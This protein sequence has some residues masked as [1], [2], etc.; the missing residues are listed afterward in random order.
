MDYDEHKEKIKE[1]AEGEFH[2]DRG[3]F[4]P[5]I[6]YRQLCLCFGAIGVFMVVFMALYAELDEIGKHISEEYRKYVTLAF[7]IFANFGGIALYFRCHDIVDEIKRGKRLKN[8]YTLIK[9]TALVLATYSL[10]RFQYI[11]M[12]Y[13]GDSHSIVR[14]VLKLIFG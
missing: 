5:T 12:H 1:R 8:T 6:L 9:S 7:V 10:L 14:V 11:N 2:K 3:L 13:N 4:Y